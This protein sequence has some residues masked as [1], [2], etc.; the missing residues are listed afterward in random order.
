MQAQEILTKVPDDL[1][2]IRPACVRDCGRVVF[3]SARLRYTQNKKWCWPWG[4]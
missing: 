2:V 1:F 4:T 3:V